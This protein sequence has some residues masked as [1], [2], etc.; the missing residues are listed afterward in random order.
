MPTV[1]EEAVATQRRYYA[2]TAATYEKMH[3]H[4]CAGDAFNWKFISA[5]LQIVDVQS[6]LDVGTATGYRVHEIR[7]TFP[8]AF[9]CGVEPVDAL[10]GIG[11]RN[12]VLASGSLIR[13]SG[14]ALPFADRSF[15]AVCE[16]AVLHH[17]PDPRAA[18]MEM[19]RVARKAVVLSDCNRFGQ[20]NLLARLAKLAM[21]KTGTWRWYDL[22][23][24]RGKGYRVTDGDGV[25][26]SYS[27]YDSFNL[28]SDWADR[29]IVIPAENGK[30]QSWMHPLITS[31]GAVAIALKGV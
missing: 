12:D 21:C 5:M 25:S 6:V 28:L 23:R 20:G 27:I 22:L 29:V 2:D 30:A 3:A 4:E 17:V 1:L 18:V 14:L 19:L 16:F 26:Y 7:S 11:R 15:D 10:I 31:P 13:G 9:V 8:E 24:T